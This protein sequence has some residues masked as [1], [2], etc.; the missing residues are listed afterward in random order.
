MCLMTWRA[1]SNSPQPWADAVASGRRGLDSI[2]RLAVQ[3]L[4][5]DDGV[6]FGGG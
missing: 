4:A 1:L 6:E 5:R 3:R 2:E